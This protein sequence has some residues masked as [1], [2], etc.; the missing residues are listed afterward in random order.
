MSA[1]VKG[2]QTVVRGTIKIVESTFQ[3][4][5]GTFLLASEGFK[6]SGEIVGYVSKLTGGKKRYFTLIKLHRHHRRKIR[7]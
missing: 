6:G 7:K 3:L 4:F 2:L 1:I 5:S